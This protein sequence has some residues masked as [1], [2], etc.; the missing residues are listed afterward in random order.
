M[1]HLYFI[2]PGHT[3]YY[4]LDS[5]TNY[6]IETSEKLLLYLK[7]FFIDNNIIIDHL[8]SSPLTKALTTSILISQFINHDKNIIP[9]DILQ[10]ISNIPSDISLNRIENLINYLFELDGTNIILVGHDN[11]FRLLFKTLF[12]TMYSFPNFSITQID[13]DFNNNCFIMISP[14]T[15]Y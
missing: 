9:N 5:S 15:L 3:D 14:P 2:Q 10:E 4:N 6:D 11:L 12:D 13:L 1:K 7:H 8:I